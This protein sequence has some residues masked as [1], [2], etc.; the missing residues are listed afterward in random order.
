MDKIPSDHGDKIKHEP[1]HPSLSEIAKKYNY[2]PQESTVLRRNIGIRWNDIHMPEIQAI[3]DQFFNIEP[4]SGSENTTIPLG[5]I[6]LPA[7]T[8]E[9]IELV[10]A[11]HEHRERSGLAPELEICINSSDPQTK[12][13]ERVA[14]FVFA[15]RTTDEG[16]IWEVGH[17]LV[18]EAFRSQAIASYIMDIFEQQCVRWT[19]M[20]DEHQTIQATVGQ[21]D[22]ISFFMKRGYVPA[23]EREG[24]RLD[25]FLK[26]DPRLVLAD[27]PIPPARAWYIFEK[28]KLFDENGA[29]RMG[30]WEDDVDGRKRSERESFRITLKKDFIATHHNVSYDSVRNALGKKV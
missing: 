2:Q 18:H 4:V 13:T 16:V 23:T 25:V 26:G 30:I 27:S 21:A 20:R 17:R 10:V 1:P 5:H 29:V 8:T 28:S 14:E 22:V 9:Q 19:K 24:Q 15:P 7:D 3:I 6:M 11:R 12:A